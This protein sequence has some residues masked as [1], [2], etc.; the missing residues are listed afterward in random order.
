MVEPTLDE[1]MQDIL[2]IVVY[3]NR[4]VGEFT[5]KELFEKAGMNTTYESFRGIL[6]SKVD[7]GL[8]SKRLAMVDGKKFMVYKKAE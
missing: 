6:D 2:G 5:A 3:P 8:L 1:L 4:E 7:R